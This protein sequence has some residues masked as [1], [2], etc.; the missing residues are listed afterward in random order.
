MQLAIPEKLDP[1]N[2]GRD[3][4]AAHQAVTPDPKPAGDISKEAPGVLEVFHQFQGH[5][6]VEFSLQRFSEVGGVEV[7]IPA[8]DSGK[9]KPPMVYF[10][11]FD[12]LKA[13]VSEARAERPLA[14]AEI[15]NPALTPINNSQFD[16][17]LARKIVK[18]SCAAD[19]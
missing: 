15:E 3:V 4:R 19:P 2:A 10:N 8:G 11:G 6:Q 7:H 9:P 1:G 18:I 17:D 12:P 14:S 5:D 13:E 16:N